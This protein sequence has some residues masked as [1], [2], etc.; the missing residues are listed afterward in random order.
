MKGLLRKDLYMTWAYGRMLL[1]ISAV[2]LF[3]SA[4]MP[5]EENFFFVDGRRCYGHRPPRCPSSP[6]G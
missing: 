5:S 2:F 6:S 3:S 4:V 1:L